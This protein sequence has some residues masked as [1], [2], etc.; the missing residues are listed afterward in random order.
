M[1]HSK[2]QVQNFQLSL[3]RAFDSLYALPIPFD[4]LN[5]EMEIGGK[6]LGSLEQSFD[7]HDPNL[8]LDLRFSSP[9]F[10]FKALVVGTCSILI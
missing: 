7:P 3:C 9:K 5:V 1:F 10:C 2:M 6:E 8:L 4:F